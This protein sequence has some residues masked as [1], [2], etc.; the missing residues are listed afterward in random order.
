MFKK[1]YN[2]LP[3]L[4]KSSIW[5]IFAIMLQK[6][7]SVLVIPIITRLL[8]IEEYAIYSLYQTW[9]G[10][11]LIICTLNLS[12]SIF[13][14]LMLKNK[15]N[16]ENITM[17]VILFEV[18]ITLIVFALYL[19]ISL[20]SIQ[21]PNISF[22]QSIVLFIQILSYIPQSIWIARMKF[23]NEYKVCALIIVLQSFALLI[24]NILVSIIFKGNVTLLICSTII[25]QLI[26]SMFLLIKMG[27]KGKFEVNINIFKYCLV[28]GSPL[29]IHYLA[30][31]ILSSSDKLL[32]DYFVGE[33]ETAIYSIAHS[34]A[35]ILQVLIIAINAAYMPWL[36]KK[37]NMKSNEYTNK[38]AIIILT[39]L[40]ILVFI[41]SLMSPEIIYIFGGSKYMEGDILIP[42]L[43]SCIIILQVYNF[44]A[45]IEF[46]YGETKVAA[47][48][49]L[50]SAMINFGLNIFFIPK[51]G[52]FAVVFTT[53]LSY[54]I[55]VVAHY[56][57]SKII[58]KKYENNICYFK[59]KAVFIIM[60]VFIVLNISTVLIYDYNYL[61]YILVAI[62]LIVMVFMVFKIGKKMLSGGE[63]DG[64]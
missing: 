42:I 61:R 45:S 7:F 12:G 13:N 55:L 17:N 56:F 14:T 5:F 1:I 60:F 41:I 34:I 24:A 54:A 3:E 53:L 6:G 22:I 9:Y 33:R 57:Y 48:A 62:I 10:F 15:E 31:N 59:D 30:Q 38:S 8:T 50:I 29:I 64:K 18:L 47:F 25:V 43:S 37:I 11:F 23:E 51:F 27:R 63:I 58:Q 21:L 44:Y 49:T 52:Y 16:K 35:F 46:V 28:V 2:N 36:Y 39:A 26:F 4:A 20:F 32:I 19:I 40:S